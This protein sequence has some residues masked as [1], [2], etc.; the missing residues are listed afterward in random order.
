MARSGTILALAM[1]LAVG[2]G[3]GAQE[4][5]LGAKGGYL[6]TVFDDLA[7]PGQEVAL[8]ARLQGGDFLRD[9]PGYAVRF[10]LSGAFYKAAETGADGVASVSFTPDQTGDYPF[11]AELAPS[12]FAAAPPEPV[13]GI[14]ACR[15][16]DSP[17][18]VVDLDKTLVASGFHQVLAGNP[19]PMA[20]SADV[21]KRLA[22]EYS[23]V[24]LTHRPDLFG[25]KSKEWL[26]RYKYPAGPLLLSDVGGFL[27]GSGTFKSGMLADL[28]KRFTGKAIGVGDKVSDVQAYH[29]NGLAGYLVV[30][31]P[32]GT[33]AAALRSLADSLD[34]VPAGVQV[35]TGWDQVERGIFSGASFPAADLQR[36]LR[37]RAD[38]LDAAAKPAAK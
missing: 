25:P 26:R 6:F 32:E 21:M 36:D 7:L 31:A 12:G 24:Y 17:L 5:L 9:Q 16:A 18:V 29:E 30:Q 27:K 13:E 3:C 19:Q 2:G 22:A 35:V 8:R 37:R 1:A 11:R 20:G 38:A 34:G 33:T 10:W 15:K 14:L 23:V 4:V 28:R